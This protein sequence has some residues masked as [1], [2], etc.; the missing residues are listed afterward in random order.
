MTTTR[1][2]TAYYTLNTPYILATA[3][4]LS[5]SSALSPSVQQNQS[6]LATKYTLY[7]INVQELQHIMCFLL[8]KKE[9]LEPSYYS[10]DI[11]DLCFFNWSSFNWRRTFRRWTRIFWRSI[12]IIYIANTWHPAWVYGIMQR[13]CWFGFLSGK[14]L[15][16]TCLPYI[17]G[18]GYC[19]CI[20]PG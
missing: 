7:T 2:Y 9:L 14:K 6:T 1:C 11:V 16:M 18:K 15:S 12:H 17:S 4:L 19:K 13:N 20:F 10:R 3:G 5:G 8:E